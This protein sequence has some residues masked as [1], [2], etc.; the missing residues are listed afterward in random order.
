MLGIDSA[1]LLNIVTGILIL[2]IGIGV[3]VWFSSSI[4]HNNHNWPGG[5]SGHV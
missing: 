3:L 5:P 1:N 2:A 4:D